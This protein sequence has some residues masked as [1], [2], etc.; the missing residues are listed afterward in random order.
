MTNCSSIE[1]SDLQI[2]HRAA[3]GWTP[4]TLPMALE[5]GAGAPKH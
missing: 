4:F 5:V 3:S 1:A 2:Q